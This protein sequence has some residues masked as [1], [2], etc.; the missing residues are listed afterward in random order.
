MDS[1]EPEVGPE[2]LLFS[3]TKSLPLSYIYLLN[4][5]NLKDVL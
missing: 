1:K 2:I 3:A 5:M 4:E